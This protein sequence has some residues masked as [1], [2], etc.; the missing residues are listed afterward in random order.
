MDSGGEGRVGEFEGRIGWGRR[1]HR[2]GKRDGN[3]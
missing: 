1:G 2:I 3:L